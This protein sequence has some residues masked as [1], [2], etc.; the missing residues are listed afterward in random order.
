L[1]F[2]PQTATDLITVALALNYK[3]P[4][5]VE[6]TFVHREILSLRIMAIVISDRRR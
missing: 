3:I 2:H 6:M 4:V 5:P 1:G